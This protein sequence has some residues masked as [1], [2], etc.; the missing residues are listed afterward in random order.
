MEPDIEK[1]YNER[2][3]DNHAVL[4]GFIPKRVPINLSVTSFAV[5]ELAGVPAVVTDRAKEIAAYLSDED[6]TGRSRNMKVVTTHKDID[7]GRKGNKGGKDTPGQ[8]SMFA[9]SEEMNITTELKNMDLDNM[10]PVKALLYLQELKER[11]K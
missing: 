7:N 3:E 11:L 9:T 1:L 4:D 2:K 5:A 10:T 8:L 6:I